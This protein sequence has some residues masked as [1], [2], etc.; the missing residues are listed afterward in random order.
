MT[1][2]IDTP[3][4]LEE[5]RRVADACMESTLR[6]AREGRL[7]PAE[8]A[9][10]AAVVQAVELWSGLRQRSELVE[11]SNEIVRL[12]RRLEARK[13]ELPEEILEKARVAVRTAVAE[14][15]TDAMKAS[16]AKASRRRKARAPK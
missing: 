4:T 3:F 5:A 11:R 12:A 6:R 2:T 7:K 15:V 16:I 13:F 1:K 14:A 10:C 9:K 8:A